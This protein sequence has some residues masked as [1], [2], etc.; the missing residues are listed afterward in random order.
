MGGSND[1]CVEIKAWLGG[2]LRGV[3]LICYNNGAVVNVVGM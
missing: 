1:R 2:E 3:F